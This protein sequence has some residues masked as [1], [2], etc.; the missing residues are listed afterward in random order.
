MRFETDFKVSYEV[1]APVPIQDIVASL[2]AVDTILHEAA[3]LLPVLFPGLLVQNIEVRVRRVVQESP[4]R[5]AFVAALLVAYQPTLTQEIPRLLHDITGQPVPGDLQSTITVLCLIITFYGVDTLR[6]FALG[7]EDGPAKK[8]LDELVK[9]LAQTS[10]MS[11]KAIHEKLDDRYGQ[12]VGWKRVTSAAL[13]FLRPSK[14]QGNA[15]LIV[16]ERLIPKQVI[17]DVPDDHIVERA[18]EELAFQSFSDVPIEL[19]AQDRDHSG[20]GWAARIPGITDRRVR[21]RLMSGVQAGQLWGRDNA[22]GDVTILYQR[23]GTGLTA[24]AINLDRL[25]R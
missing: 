13:S 12:K 22:R 17:A 25:T 14:K 2:Q 4:L 10:G 1:E 23:D 6:R 16:N 9:E 11:E 21:L 24:K 18:S 15:E 3:S 7:P 5:E 19:H 20:Q 8:K